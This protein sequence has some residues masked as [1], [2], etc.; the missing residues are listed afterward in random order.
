MR[1][2]RLILA[3]M[4]LATPMLYA[5]EAG[6]QKTEP[7]PPPPPAPPAPPAPLAHDA[8]Q[9]QKDQ[10]PPDEAYRIT[11]TFKTTEAGKT[12][13]QRT[14]TM[15]ATSRASAPRIRDDSRIY[16]KTSP[17]SGQYM[18]VRTDLDILQ[19][20]RTKT[21]NDVLLSLMISTENFVN[22]PTD[23]DPY[24]PPII[25]SRQYNVTPTLPIGKLV[26]VCTVVDAANDS[27]VD[28]QVLVQPLDAK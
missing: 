16:V 5:Q 23:Q 19:F 8:S 15:V 4:L 26:T 20:I 21:G 24:K 12:T 11:I 2:L 7:L 27:K 17:S 13:T 1:T 22:N 9:A 25:R 28:V 3:V 10:T 18:D 14:Y 6:T